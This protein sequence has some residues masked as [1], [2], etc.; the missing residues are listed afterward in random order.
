MQTIKILLEKHSM[1]IEE[2]YLC[3]TANASMDT[4]FS[5]EFNSDPDSIKLFAIDTSS[6]TEL[7][8]GE[9]RMYQI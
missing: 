1:K 5:L 4:K 3:I 2:S 8:G 9:K 6:S 7:K